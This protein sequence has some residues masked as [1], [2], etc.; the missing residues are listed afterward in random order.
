M[1]TPL[2]SAPLPFERTEIRSGPISR[3]GFADY[4][5][6]FTSRNPVSPDDFQPLSLLGAQVENLELA[7]KGEAN[8]F[9]TILGGYYCE[10]NPG[11]RTGTVEISHI[12]GIAADAGLGFGLQPGDHCLADAWGMKDMFGSSRIEMMDERSKGEDGWTLIV[13]YKPFRHQYPYSGKPMNIFRDCPEITTLQVRQTVEKAEQVEVE[14]V[15]TVQHGPAQGYRWDWGDG[16]SPDETTEPRAT[17]SYARHAGRDHSYAVK[18]S[19]VGLPGCDSE[20]QAQLAIPGY[21]PVLSLGAVELAYPSDEEA[22]VTV[23]IL[24]NH[25]L[26]M[27]YRWD[28]GDGSEPATTELPNASHTYARGGTEQ[29]YAITVQ[30]EGPGTCRQQL[31]ARVSVAPPPCP[32]V[33]SLEAF[34]GTLNNDAFAVNFEARMTRPAER[35]IWNFG[36]G[37]AEAETREPK[38]SHQF[39][40]ATGAQ[41]SRTVSVRAEGGGQD[42]QSLSTT[43]VMVPGVCP[44]LDTQVAID[45]LTERA[46]IAKLDLLVQGPAPI[47]WT[48]NWGDG[49]MPETVEGLT[50]THSYQRPAGNAENYLIQIQANGLGECDHRLQAEVEVPGRCPVVQQLVTEWQPA[51][52]GKY[53]L[54]V[55]AVVDGPAPS[56]YHW[57]WGDGSPVETTTTPMAQHLYAAAPGQETALTLAVE[58]QG[59]DSCTG[60]KAVQISVPAG[61]CPLLGQFTI[62][63]QRI[64]GKEHEIEAIAIFQGGQPATFTWD[65]GDGGPEETTSVPRATHVYALVPGEEQTYRVQLQ[66]QGPGTCQSLSVGEVATAGP[67]PVPG[68]LV[69]HL[70]ADDPETAIVQARLTIQGPPAASYLWDWGDGSE[71]ETTPQPMASHRYLTTPGESNQGTVT[72]TVQGPGSC[73]SSTHS[74]PWTVQA[75]PLFRELTAVTADL[76]DLEADVQFSWAGA[77]Q[78]DQYFWDFGDG[79]QARTHAPSVQH[80][81]ARW[82]GQP[83]AYTV[84]VQAIGPRDCL[85]TGSTELTIPAP[86]LCPQIIRIDTFVQEERDDDILIG[87]VPVA[88]GAIPERYTWDFGDGNDPDTSVEPEIFHRYPKGNQDSYTVTLTASGPGN[89][90]VQQTVVVSVPGLKLCPELGGLSLAGKAAGA[91]W[92]VDAQLAVTTGKPTHF[93]WH[94]DDGTAVQQTMGPQAS[95]AYSQ[96]ST[97]QPVTVRVEAIGPDGCHAEVSQATEVPALTTKHPWCRWWPRLVAF[98]AALAGG[99]WLVCPADWAEVDQAGWLPWTLVLLIAAFAAAVWWWQRMGKQRLCPPTLCDGLAVGW[100]MGLTMTGVA[101]FLQECLPNWIAWG[102]GSFVVAAVLAGWW[103]WKC[104]VTTRARIFLLYF[105]LALAAFAMVVLLIA[106]LALSCV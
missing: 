46:A 38:A 19:T 67:C 95:H 1:P 47:S 79:Q 84:T 105:G 106:M 99:A 81:Y 94:W 42:C 74:A 53:P 85:Q 4:G 10:R 29:P 9:F 75:C 22:H 23:Q 62:R 55:R 71:P 3:A 34:P 82:A 69:L 14:A 59:P 36:D 92:T 54:Q 52:A 31:S 56:A 18:A 41:I 63:N 90:E 28:W 104:A 15:V 70:E 50:T 49:T 80:T 12:F 37:S 5:V 73:A 39:A 32:E 27:A 88:V 91:G 77:G 64:T 8:R 16:S 57:N 58:V 101:F 86:E 48:I 43:Q 26:G 51:Q 7:N 30:S 6:I 33:L 89:C 61:A 44:L 98:L 66:T 24:G 83:N 35:Y 65:W 17:H 60:S 45:Q 100:V 72:V 21:C 11:G 97:P 20:Q 76:R 25:E 13:N 2:I 68:E 102:I 40:P 96:Q 103:F 87:F 93:L 78:A